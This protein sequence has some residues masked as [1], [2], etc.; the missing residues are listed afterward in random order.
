MKV[1]I[2]RCFE[3]QIV[4]AFTNFDLSSKIKASKLGF[5]IIII[6]ERS[7]ISKFYLQKFGKCCDLLVFAYTEE[8]NSNPCFYMLRGQALECG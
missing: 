1:Q 3:W 5:E 7:C 8:I 2:A 6:G 4:E